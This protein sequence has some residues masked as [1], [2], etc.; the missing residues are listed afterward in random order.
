VALAR[1]VLQKASVLLLDEPTNHLDIPSQEVLQ[2]VLGGFDGTAIFVS[3]DRY[4][5]RAL[6]THIWAVADGTITPL[7]GDWEKY[8]QWRDRG[9]VAS[10]SP[11][12]AEA[13]RIKEDRKE[14]HKDRRRRTNEA[15]SMRRRLAEV[16]KRIG[17]LETRRAEIH[18][19]IS[20]AGEAGNLAEVTRQGREFEQVDQRLRELL[21]EWESLSLAM[22]KG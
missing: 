20:R 5:I 2:E 10:A 4:L 19:E 17:D 22:E 14:Q 13:V 11:L 16:E 9:R 3:H 6:A 15:L 7:P 1:L 8:V 12:R 18:D 21:A